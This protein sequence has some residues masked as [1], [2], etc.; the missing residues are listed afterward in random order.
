[1]KSSS[2]FQVSTPGMC[3]AAREASTRP[4]PSSTTVFTCIACIESIVRAQSTG[5]RRWL[6]S[7]LRRASIVCSA[8]PVAL[9][10]IGNAGTLIGS[11]STSFLK[12]APA[13]SI[14]GECAARGMVRISARRAPIASARRSASSTAGI[15]PE[16]TNCTSALR[17][18]MKS[19]PSLPASTQ[20]VSTAGCSRP[21]IAIIPPGLSTAAWDM[22]RPRSR[23]SR[24]AVSQEMAPAA[25]RAVNS[26]SE[27]PAMTRTF[28][29]P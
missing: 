23:T 1:M 17:L 18:A 6:A 22:I 19:F 20:I 5:R 13:R 10:R 8:S 3:F 16:R 15:S 9:A 12:A 11:A 7:S 25:A 27:W 26:P 14:R 28:S 2:A 4:G 24:R 29:S 21:T